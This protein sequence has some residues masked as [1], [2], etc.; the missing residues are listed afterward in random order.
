MGNNVN[1]KNC[2]Y[3]LLHVSFMVIP[4]QKHIVATQK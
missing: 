3:M 1:I 2:K 4:K